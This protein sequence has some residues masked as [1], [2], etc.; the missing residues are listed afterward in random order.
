MRELSAA[1][2]DHFV[3]PRHAGDL[4]ADQPGVI[5]VRAEV[6]TSGEILQL[7]LHV[8][9]RGV[10]AETVAAGTRQRRGLDHQAHLGIQSRRTRVEIERADEHALA[11]D[12]E[13]LGVQAGR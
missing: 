2:R 8:N 1:A 9:E 10:I 12:R 6:P 13:G 7:Q 4:D 3:H 5:T 11:V